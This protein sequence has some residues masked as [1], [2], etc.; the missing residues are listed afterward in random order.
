M[1]KKYLLFRASTGSDY[2]SAEFA[3]IPLPLG[4]NDIKGK[5]RILELNPDLFQ[6]SVLGDLATFYTDSDQLPDEVYALLESVGDDRA[7]EV[8]LEDSLV[9]SLSK[10]L[11]QLKY[12]EVVFG[13]DSVTFSVTGKHS[14]SEFW[15]SCSW[16][17]L[18]AHSLN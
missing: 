11:E 12:G 16:D 4:L 6:V 9:E 18:L 14:G 3:L 17:D 7:C 13:R 2:E 8:E 10:V 15:C 1:K 5:Q